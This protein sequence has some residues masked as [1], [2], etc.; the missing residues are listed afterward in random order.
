[1]KV[2][3][4]QPTTPYQV[5]DIWV[6][7]TYPSDGSTYKNEVLRCQ[8]NKAAGSQFAIGDWIKASK[9][10]DDTVANAAKKAA[11]DAQKAAQT[12]Q[13]DIKN[14][15]K[16][17][18]DNKKEFD[19]YVTDGYLE[20]S[21]I[22]AM[23]QDSK[24][25]EDDFAAAQKSYNEVK[26]A[27]VL[28]D[29]KELTDLNTAFATLT[30]AK[31]ELVT[32]LS[33]ISSRYNAA[34]TNVKATIVSAV[35]TKFTNFQSAYSAFYDKLGLANAYITSK[36]WRLEAEYYRPCRLQVYQGRARSDYRY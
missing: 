24:R 35:G 27:E 17:V 34:D 36:I 33:D 29:T 8:T 21:E 31:T 6:N 7:A 22:A 23:A 19:N 9:Y 32:Y 25:L 10:T 3:S 2:F 5:G 30:T 12:A 26:N 14:L 15:G 4:V 18:T 20:P 13:T 1:M 28:K 16:T 11:E